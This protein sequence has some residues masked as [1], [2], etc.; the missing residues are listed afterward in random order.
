[1]S[2]GHC[3]IDW[4][5]S[6]L[7]S[8]PQILIMPC[9][10][11]YRTWKLLNLDTVNNNKEMHKI[12]VNHFNSRAMQ[13]KD[14]KQFYNEEETKRFSYKLLENLDYNSIERK[15]TLFSI[16]DAYAFAKNID[17]NNIKV[18]IEHEHVSFPYK[19][20]IKDFNSPKIL[21]IYRDPRASIAGYYKGIN[22]KYGNWPDI[23]E[24][25]INMSIEEWMNSI[26]FYK[27]Y[28]N[29]LNDKFKLVKN[30]ALIRNTKTE[31]LKI[32]NWLDIDYRNSLIKSSYPSGL[33]WI[34][35]SSY[36]NRDENYS[37]LED[38]YFSS[39]RIKQR[40]LN[41]LNDKRDIIMIEFLFDDFMQ[42]FG[43]NRITKNNF[44]T[45]I[46]GLL[47]FIRPHR[48]PNRFNNYRIDKNEILRVSNRLKL[49]NTPYKFYFW[50]AIPYQF[51][52][53][54]I[55]FNSVIK[56]IIM[57]FFPGNRWKRYDD[58]ILNISYRIT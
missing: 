34:P 10:S 43:Y 44:Y 2:F 15:K 22:K 53:L 4:L 42:K 41:V 51:Q 11:F 5:H 23:Y 20:I 57:Y 32:S 14:T 3:G 40:W 18:I 50:N 46:K 13:G 38:N 12:W 37:N 28:K 48:G 29:Q 9:F 7:D 6:L 19:E 31:M 33:E 58:P 16:F 25:F 52:K 1:M 54:L 55:I 17:L 56:H 36:L 30:E 24:Y 47:Y 35:D 39:N 45:K 21:M 49:L 27:Q 26:D 8:H